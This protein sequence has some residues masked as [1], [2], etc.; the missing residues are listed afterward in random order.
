LDGH[1]LSIANRATEEKTPTSRIRD[2]A[3]KRRQGLAAQVC[4]RWLE[5]AHLGEQARLLVTLTAWWGRAF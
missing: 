1:R 4:S 3:K 2:A 5:Q